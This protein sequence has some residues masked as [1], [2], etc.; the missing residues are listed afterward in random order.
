MK[1]YITRKTDGK[2]CEWCMDVA[3]RYRYGEEPDDIYRRHDNCDCTVTFENGR[4]R[5]DV[6]SKREWEAPE[7]GAG[8][9]DPVVLT[10]EQ[11]AAAG[12]DEPINFIGKEAPQNDLTADKKRSIMKAITIQDIN[13][14]DPSGIIDDEC[15]KKIAETLKSQGVSY[16]YDK[17]VLFSKPRD[18]DGKIEP[19]ITDAIATPG[20]PEVVLRINIDFFAGRSLEKIDEMFRLQKYSVAKSLEEAVIHECAHAKMLKGI[21][22]ARYEAIDQELNGEFFTKPIKERK[23]KKSLK[24]LA[25]GL[26]EYAQTDCLDCIAESHVVLHR[27]SAL[28]KEL[29]DLHDAYVR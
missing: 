16:V 12:A 23:D 21:T 26:S 25:G 13:D 8:A 24:D 19:L 27:G 15:R 18:E 14:S 6:W 1:C 2:C 22:Y 7:P 9:G 17:V 3:G 4:K 11:S 10:K 5:Q 20:Y 28:P 29:K